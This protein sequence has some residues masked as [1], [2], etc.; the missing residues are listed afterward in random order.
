MT[1]IEELK[2]IASTLWHKPSDRAAIERAIA[3]LERHEAERNAKTKGYR[4]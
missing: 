1:L 3:E 2:V 4:V